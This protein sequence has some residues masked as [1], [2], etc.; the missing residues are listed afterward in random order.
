MSVGLNYQSWVNARPCRAPTRGPSRSRRGPRPSAAMTVVALF[1]VALLVVV[2]AVA[3]G[4]PLATWWTWVAAGS[5][6]GRVGA[7]GPLPPPHHAERGPR[8]GIARGLRVGTVPGPGAGQGAGAVHGPLVVTGAIVAGRHRRRPVRHVLARAHHADARLV[9]RADP[10]RRSRRR[11]HQ[12]GVDARRAPRVRPAPGRVPR[13]GRQC[14]AAPAALRRRG[15]APHGAV[16]G[17]HRP[18][19]RGIRRHAR[20]RHGR[21][22]PGMRGRLGRDPRP[23]AV[24][25][26]RH[27]HEQPQ[28]GRRLGLP[29]PP[30]APVAAAPS[31]PAS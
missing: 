28:R 25:R 27:R 14:R 23:S 21:R 26:A 17:E 3:V 13:R 9:R 12:D 29:A 6:R 24:L 31:S 8:G 1:D 20:G 30:P 4:L 10:V 7:L 19:R 22:L 18:S 15:H 5:G 2:V 11:Q 16:R